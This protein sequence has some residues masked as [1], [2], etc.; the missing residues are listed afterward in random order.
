MR[1]C[2]QQQEETFEEEDHTP[3]KNLCSSFTSVSK[4]VDCGSTISSKASS[5]R[6]QP[7]NLPDTMETNYKFGDCASIIKART[8][9]ANS[10]GSMSGISTTV[11]LQQFHKTL[12]FLGVPQDKANEIRIF[13]PCSTGKFLARNVLEFVACAMPKEDWAILSA[14]PSKQDPEVLKAVFSRVEHNAMQ[15]MLAFEA[16][17]EDNPNDKKSGGRKLKPGLGK[18]VNAHKKWIKERL[19]LNTKDASMIP[20]QARSAVLAQAPPRNHSVAHMFAARK[21]KEAALQAQEDTWKAASKLENPPKPRQRT[22]KWLGRSQKQHLKR[23][24]PPMQ[25]WLG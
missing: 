20:L 4:S 1:Q 22:K 8:T 16:Q 7:S 3:Q 23:Q 17:A 9:Q 21:K 12:L 25:Q 13:P 15:E 11:M 6:T 18:W 24:G 10:E 14:Q 19:S 2:W 5:H